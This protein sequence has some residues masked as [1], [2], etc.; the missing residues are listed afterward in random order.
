MAACMLR[1][2][3]RGRG[4][5]HRHPWTQTAPDR[6]ERQAYG[7]T[8]VVVRAGLRS[9]RWEVRAGRFMEDA[10]E[11]LFDAPQEAM[12]AADEVAAVHAQARALLGRKA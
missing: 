6:F 3:H 1:P 10:S 12:W 9:W 8:L 4:D 5:D 11:F 7:Y 2:R